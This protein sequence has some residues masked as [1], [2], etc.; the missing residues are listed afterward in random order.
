MDKRYGRVQWGP[1]GTRR[2]TTRQYWRKPYSWNTAAA[3]EGRRHRVFCASL[4][5]VFEDRSELNDW[6][7]ELFA[8]IDATP[9]LDW[10]LLTKRPQNIGAMLSAVGPSPIQGSALRNNIW[11]GTSVGDQRTA[12]RAVPKLTHWRDLASILFLS[13]EPLLAPIPDLPLTSIDWV[14]V[15]GESGIGARPMQEEWVFD[16]KRQCD[17]ARVPFFFKQWGG[18]NKKAAGRLLGGITYDSSPSPHRDRR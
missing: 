6:R 1:T 14:I 8:V 2:R 11:L 10:L 12:D 9:N 3:E 16:I 17:A 7:R 13:V 15:G 4:A 5:D 18:F